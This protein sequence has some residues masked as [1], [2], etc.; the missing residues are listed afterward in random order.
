MKYKI[1]QQDY[2]IFRGIQD[3]EIPQPPYPEAGY[4]E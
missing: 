3:W 2:G 1:A 4:R